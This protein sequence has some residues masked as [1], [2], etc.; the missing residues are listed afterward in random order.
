MKTRFATTG[1]AARMLEIY[2]PYVLESPI[3]FETEVPDLG[4]F[5]ERIREITAK[6]PW[7]VYE[8]EGVV[9]GYAYA[10]THRSRC[11]YE[12]SVE[13]TVY[14]DKKHHGKGIGTELYQE[15]FGLL[16]AQG[17]VNVFAGITQPNERSVRLHESLGF[18]GVGIFKD[19][20]FKQGKWW[21]VGWWQLQ[22]QKPEHPK[23]L[24]QSVNTQLT[25]S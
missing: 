14:V 16:K 8:I 19:I 22:L 12:W 4:E 17:A 21:D 23:P 15:L 13:S 20:G 6:F 11:A 7:L 24:T 3:S 18:T 25:E 2:A 5:Q 9:V 10:S 1:D